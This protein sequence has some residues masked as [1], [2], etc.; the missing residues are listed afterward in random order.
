M[1][2]QL[3]ALAKLSSLAFNDDGLDG[4]TAGITRNRSRRGTGVGVGTTSSGIHWVCQRPVVDNL[5]QRA[6]IFDFKLRNPSYASG[7]SEAATRQVLISYSVPESWTSR[8]RIPVKRAGSQ[9]HPL[10]CIKHFKSSYLIA[11][12]SGQLV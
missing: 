3:K 12:S 1:Q 11:S 5:G 2:V 7:R 10:T 6:S 9:T 4:M 8:A